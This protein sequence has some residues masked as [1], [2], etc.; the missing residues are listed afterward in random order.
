M[1]RIVAL[2]RASPAPTECARLQ[3]VLSDSAVG[4]LP[5]GQVAEALQR[6]TREQ[7]SELRGVRQEI[8]VAM[9]RAQSHVLSEYLPLLGSSPRSIKQIANRLTLNLVALECLLWTEDCPRPE[10]DSVVRFTITDVRWPASV[11]RV[12]KARD[13]DDADALRLTSHPSGFRATIMRDG[14]P[15]PLH[16]YLSAAGYPVVPEGSIKWR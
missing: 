16:E 12:I 8:A 1:A 10:L 13:A 9:G 4:A 5:S 2:G 7:A 15:L 3:I 14:S 11:D 6:V